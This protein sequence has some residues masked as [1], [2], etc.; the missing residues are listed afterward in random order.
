MEDV[1]QSIGQR[2]PLLEDPLSAAHPSSKQVG[3]QGNIKLIHRLEELSS[4]G[5]DPR[6]ME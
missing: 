5:L 6:L 4:T 2:S 3:E 1:H